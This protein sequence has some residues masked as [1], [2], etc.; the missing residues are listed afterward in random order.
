[1][2]LPLIANLETV[3]S[4]TTF[5]ARPHSRHLAQP[6]IAPGA[7]PQTPTS[8]KPAIHPQPLPLRAIASISTGT[9]LGSSLTATQERAGLW[10]KYFS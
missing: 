6:R 4:M 5:D 2:L 8:Q 1:M 10:V 9:P 3:S 7:Q